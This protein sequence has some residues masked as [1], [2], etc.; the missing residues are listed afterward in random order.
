MIKSTFFVEVILSILL[1]IGYFV[2]FFLRYRKKP[3]FL[4]TILWGIGGFFVANA[5]Y[6]VVLIAITSLM[7]EEALVKI[8][9][10]S[11]IMPVL[12]TTF[13]LAVGA[14]FS[15]TFVT[16]MQKKRANY[17]EGYTDEATGF[18]VGAGLIAPPFGQSAAMIN[19]SLMYF[20]QMFV[21]GYVIN[22]NPPLEELG[23]DVTQEMWNELVASFT[24]IQVFDLFYLALVTVVM[25]LSYVILFKLLVRV[26]DKKP[27]WFKYGVPLMLMWSFMF[28]VSLVSGLDIAS[29]IKLLLTLGFGGLL[30]Y[31]NRIIDARGVSVEVIDPQ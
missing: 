13:A 6:N 17:V 5:I 31:A 27:A 4:S 16:R 23:P 3:G 18:M 20:V 29:F 1:F 24:S 22:Q 15:A 14:V 25:A 21:N 28:L 11:F 2:F 19:A 9:E 30:Y 12:I 7:G 8:L 26:F 10:N